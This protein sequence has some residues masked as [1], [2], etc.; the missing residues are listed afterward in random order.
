MSSTETAAGRRAPNVLPATLELGPVHLTV[1]DLERSVAWYASALGLRVH[2]RE[3]SQAALGT[4]AD[5]VL[6]LHED[7]AALPA[8]RHA[9]LYHYALLYATREE[10]ARG[11]GRLIE[12][13][14][15]IQGMSDHGT[16]EAIY[17]PDVDGNGI[18]LAADRPRGEW[19]QNA[20]AHGPSPLDLDSLLN[21]VRG[22]PVPVEAGPGLRVGHLHLQVG[23]IQEGLRFYGDVL[24]FELQA[25]I[26]TAAFLSAGGYHHHVAFNV[27]AGEGIAPQPEHAA[28]LHHW[29]VR[30]PTDG[31]VADIRSRLDGNGLR[32]EE[33]AGGFR[34]HDP[35]RLAVDFVSAAGPGTG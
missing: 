28:G 29:T 26:G 18:E 12:T 7:G 8:G 17:L 33:V 23:D 14:T 24:G 9:G 32:V 15:P 22:E 27:W 35:W 2:G 21:T 16:H 6:V 4:G 20:Y 5:P 25:N 31:D 11:A 3:E 34:A 19:P 30:L 10:L 13:R 1:P